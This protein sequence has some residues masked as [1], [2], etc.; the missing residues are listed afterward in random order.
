[1]SM[2]KTLVA[3]LLI[4]F[5]HTVGAAELEAGQPAPGFAGDSKAA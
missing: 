3:L 1:M 2:K 5:G 4:L